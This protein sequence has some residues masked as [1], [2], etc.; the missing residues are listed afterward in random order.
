MR[1]LYLMQVPWSW[2][3]Q[4]PHFLAEHLAQD[5]DVVLVAEREEKQNNSVQNEQDSAIKF[6]TFPKLFKRSGRFASSLNFWYK[7][8]WISD[9]V[10]RSRIIWITYPM[11][12]SYIK[13]V[14]RPWHI[15]IYDC[16]DD[17]PAFYSDPSVQKGLLHLEGV[18]CRRANI[19]FAS[20]E[21]LKKT[22][23][24]R[25]TP[26]RLPVVVNNG[27]QPPVQEE[28]Q[29]VAQ[30]DNMY[31]KDNK[32]KLVYIGT[33]AH[34][35][36]FDTMI[37]VLDRD[38]SLELLLFGPV[39]CVIPAHS[40][41][42]HCGILNHKDIFAVMGHADLLIMPF[43]LN[44]IVLKVNPVKAYEYV[45]SGKPVAMIRYSETEKFS[46]FVN[47]YDDSASLSAIIAAI[48]GEGPF[49]NRPLEECRK[50]AFQNTWDSRYKDVRNSLNEVL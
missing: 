36:D 23:I 2:I 34:W 15:V 27:I 39:D 32:F 44:D 45:Y 49:I 30:P 13:H 50:F 25:H 14:I 17:T 4:R 37:T 46:E 47:L 29:V 41:I 11:Q 3:K 20:S 31:S 40:Q 48:K 19:I 8:L 1:L 26:A 33:I 5:F 18:L 43:I 38:N 28:I 35:F 42:R 9:S 24:E 10:L 22:L 12:W 6:L 21:A 16:M 7:K